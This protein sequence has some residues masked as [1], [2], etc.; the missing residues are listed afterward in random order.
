MYVLSHP[1]YRYNL[2]YD[3]RT[4]KHKNSACVF[5]KAELESGK[6]GENFMRFL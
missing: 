5:T 6:Y 2:F 4:Q 3:K 1:A